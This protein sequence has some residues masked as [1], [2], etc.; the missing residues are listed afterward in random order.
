MVPPTGS[1]PFD[2]ASTDGD[3]YVGQPTGVMGSLKQMSVTEILQT[4]EIGK[5]SARVDV[6]TI[7]GLKGTI[8]IHD[9]QIVHASSPTTVG[10]AVIGLLIRKTEGFFRIHYEKEQ[11][12]RNIT[13]PTQFVLLEAMRMMDEAKVAAPAPSPPP[14]AAVRTV[15]DTSPTA[16]EKPSPRSA[17]AV[18]DA[19]VVRRPVA[20]RVPLARPLDAAGSAA[21]DAAAS[22]EPAAS[23]ERAASIGDGIE[24]EGGVEPRG[25]VEEATMPQVPTRGV[26][27][28]ALAL[29]GLRGAKV[30]TLDA[31]RASSDVTS[32]FALRVMQRAPVWNADAEEKFAPLRPRLSRV[33]PRLGT[34]PLWQIAV[35]LVTVLACLLIVVT[36]L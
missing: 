24:R 5:K 2:T 21:T 34:L 31:W 26:R 12:E 17:P 4:L 30:W 29:Q 6:Q 9:G 14:S 36:A 28:K 10:E 3:P 18:K 25:I 11:C 27:A 8:H 7:D 19:V 20:E 32:Q 33:H 16:P 1:S 22:Q 13:R 15:V 23:A 35:T